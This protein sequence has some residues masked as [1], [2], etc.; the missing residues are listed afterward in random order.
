MLI[1][2]SKLYYT[3]SGIITLCRWPCGAQVEKGPLHIKFRRR[4]ITQMTNVTRRNF[5]IKKYRLHYEPACSYGPH[6]P[7]HVLCT[8]PIRKISCVPIRQAAHS[9][10][11]YPEQKIRPFSSKRVTTGRSDEDT[12][13]QRTASLPRVSRVTLFHVADVMTS[14]KS[15]VP[16]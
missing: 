8:Y 7:A 16:C 11:N 10:D 3:A 15:N 6:H 13:L 5:E 2:R 4:G 9:T 12:T 14:R 1:V